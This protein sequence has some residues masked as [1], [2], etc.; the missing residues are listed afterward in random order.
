MEEI[1]A[2]FATTQIKWIVI[3]LGVDI[4]FG[5]IGAL[6]K[7]DFVFW[8]LTKFMKG[9]VLGYVLGFAVLELVAQ[10]LPGLSFIAPTAFVLIAISLVASIIG[11]LGKWGVPLPKWLSK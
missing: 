4:I 6:I 2:L 7:K 5:I 9:P 8:Q 3:L 11:N 10:A 1:I